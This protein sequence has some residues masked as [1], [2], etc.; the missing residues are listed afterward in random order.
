MFHEGESACSGI[1]FVIRIQ[2]GRSKVRI[3]FFKTSMSRQLDLWLRR[4]EGIWQH[5][6]IENK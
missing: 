5:G 1:R 6:Q 3:N 4:N 2:R